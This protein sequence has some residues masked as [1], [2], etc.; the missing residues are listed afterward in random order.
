MERH[1]E[2]AQKI[3]EYLES[4]AKV[5]KVN[6]PGLKSH[7]QYELAKMQMSGFGGILSFELNGDHT[8]TR[9]F[10]K[11][12]KIFALA[13]SLGGVES[14]IECPASMTHASVPE[15]EREKIGITEN[16]IRLSIGIENIDDLIGDL[17]CALSYV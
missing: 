11:K 14:L 10:L 3:A 1:N 4:H 16:L 7:P 5:K 9:A 13:E 6:Y 12:L 8:K 17:G 2:N 15:K